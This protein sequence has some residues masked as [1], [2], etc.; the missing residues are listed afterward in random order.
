MIIFR[1]AEKSIKEARGGK[2]IT[3]DGAASVQAVRITIGA[4]VDGTIALRGRGIVSIGPGAETIEA[5]FRVGD[6]CGCPVS[7]AHL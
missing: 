2:F 1:L 6:G 4:L 3:K 5:C 7:G